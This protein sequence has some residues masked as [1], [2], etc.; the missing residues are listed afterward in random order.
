MN[1]NSIKIPKQLRGRD[2]HTNIIPT[3]CN[4]KNML[5]KLKIVNGDYKKLKQ[6]EK[7]SYQ[8]YLIDEINEQILNSAIEENIEI[9]RNHILKNNPYKLGASCIDI[10]LVAYVAE[11]YGTGK[12][13]FFKYIFESGISDKK[14]SAQ[15]IWQVGKGDGIFLRILNE[16]GSV[17]DW[18]F[19]IN[20]IKGEATSIQ[21]LQDNI[22]KEE[23]C[24]FCTITDPILQNELAIGFFDKYP[25]NKG[26]LL[27]IP[28]RHVDQYFDL[29]IEERQAI[30]DLLFQ[31]KSLVDEEY[32]PA[33]Y[34]IG[35]NNGEVAGQTIFHVHVHLIPRYK[36]DME[37]PRGGVRGVIPEKRMY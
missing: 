25:V 30:D 18:N 9:I 19:F 16:D 7:R 8:A 31:G 17:R 24:P 14:N 6:W 12:D 11:T 34:N 36:G 37:E 23:S 35:I 2:L 4:L 28:R 26:H 33:G 21:Q 29:K 5:N 27:I 3:V 10:Y 32:S 15:A 20:W 1:E 13:T 22:D